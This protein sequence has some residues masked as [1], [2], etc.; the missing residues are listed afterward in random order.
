[1]GATYF[2]A[3][4]PA[5]KREKTITLLDSHADR[6]QIDRLQRAECGLHQIVRAHKHVPREDLG[7]AV[8]AVQGNSRRQA[9]AFVVD[10][11][12]DLRVQ[13]ATEAGT[14]EIPGSTASTTTTAATTNSGRAK[15]AT[16]TSS[17][18]PTGINTRAAYESDRLFSAI[19]KRHHRTPHFQLV[20]SSSLDHLSAKP[21]PGSI[22]FLQVLFQETVL[23]HSTDRQAASHGELSV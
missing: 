17:T 21:V 16:S 12:V 14:D 1:M 7:P 13:P 20:I 22:G 9:Q 2:H 5:S 15:T 19:L 8:V 10:L 18:S 3:P 6:R 23:R 11:I 4:V